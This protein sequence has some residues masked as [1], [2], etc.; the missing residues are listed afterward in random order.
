MDNENKNG[1][2]E[3]EMTEDIINEETEEVIAKAEEN[4]AEEA[5]ADEYQEEETEEIPDDTQAEPDEDSL[6]I[7][8]GEKV[9]NE[10]SD[11]CSEC[12]AAMYKRKIPFL[13]WISGVAVI[14]VSI[15]A[16]VISMLVSA[17]VL[18]AARGDTS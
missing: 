5:V 3:E 18:Q 11:Y 7:I 10:E 4:D 15:F 14:C 6:C 2:N 12:E 17:P 8:C 16:F 1:L 9:K 13:A